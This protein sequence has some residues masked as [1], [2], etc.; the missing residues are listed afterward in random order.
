MS[1]DVTHVVS[2]DSWD[3]NFDQ[4]KEYVDWAPPIVYIP[5]LCRL[6]QRM[7]IWFLSDPHGCL[8]V[9]ALELCCRTSPTRSH[10]SSIFVSLP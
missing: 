1:E 4:V 8:C 5:F 7:I 10:N 3:E 6:W 9:T 2:C